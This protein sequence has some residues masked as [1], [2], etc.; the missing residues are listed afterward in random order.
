MLDLNLTDE[1]ANKF[2]PFL[3]EVLSNYEEKIESIH[4]VGSA[5]T[6][7]FDSKASDINSVIV[8]KKMDL[9]FLS[10]LAPLGNKYGK[11]GISAPLIMTPEYIKNSL[12]VFPIEFLNIKQIHQTVFGEDV[13]K[14][15]NIERNDLRQQCE[16]ELKVKLIGLRQGYISA[17]GDRKII[18][19]N[20]VKSITGYIPLFR[21]I[22]VLC[23]QAPP[24]LNEEILTALEEA[25]GVNTDVF[26]AVLKEKKDRAK[27]SMETLNTLFEDYYAATEKLG[28]IID[29]IKI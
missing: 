9:K 21:G 6:K 23:G 3:N 17:T 4:V 10:F 28:G 2:K 18:T 25:T 11:K 8:L 19:E 24:L 20:F 29:G 13:F 14:E 1:V 12:D 26:K 5:L 22:V 7:D 27:L 16:R 15:L